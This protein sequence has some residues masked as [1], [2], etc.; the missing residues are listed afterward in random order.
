MR[1][2]ALITGATGF[3]GR[4]LTERL[5][6][7]GWWVR[8]LVR[9]T[10]DTRHLEQLGVELHRGDLAD[11]AALRRASAGVDV[12]F[13]LAAVTGLRDEK[14]FARANIEG[15]RHLVSAVR[16]AEPRPRRLVYLSSYAACGPA[17]PGRPRRPGDRPAPLTEYGRSKLAGEEE[18]LREC[19]GALESVIVRAP[20]V[21]GPGDHALLPYFRLVRWGVA[22]SPAGG[23]RELHLIYA[24]DLALA[25]A[26]AAEVPAGIYPVAEPVV[27]RWSGIV[28]AMAEGLGR[29]PLALPLPPALVRSAAALAEGAGALLRR[30]VV[31]N[32]EKAR[33]MLAPAWTCDLTGSEA[34]LSAREATPLAEG[35]ARTVEWYTRQGWL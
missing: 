2:R 19:E 35:V 34:L 28:R 3:V 25:L 21:Y 15:T 13:H 31:F 4:H 27:H 18:V 9:P 7:E 32:R 24:P 23:D 12:V 1:R 33:E 11:E 8:A 17:E 20:A 5:A 29:R 26:R 14:D 22:P 16:R 6:A 10:S 30:T